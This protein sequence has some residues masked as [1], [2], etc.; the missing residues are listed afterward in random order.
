MKI[1]VIGKGGREHALVWKLAAS[2]RVSAVYCAPG[3]AGTAAEGNNVDISPTDFPRLVKFAKEE[4]IDLTVVGPEGPL[5]LGIVDTFT[6]EGLRIFGPTKA[7]A[8]LEGSKVFSK[9]LMRGAGVPTADFHVFR[10]ADSARLFVTDREDT[11]VV[12][13][14]DGLAADKGVIVCGSRDEAL[15]AIL[16]PRECPSCKSPP[17]RPEGE[18]DFYCVN[19]ECPAQQAERIRHFVSRGAM[20]IETMGPVLIEQLIADDRPVASFPLIE[21][22]LD[23]GSP[24]DYDRAQEIA[25]N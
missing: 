14:A 9:E 23:I 22:W 17:V 18:V 12:V 20:D 1:L 7:A 15:E 5:V 16:S 21:Q 25:R 6:A 3:N 24:A 10:D 2:P 11:P 19:P 8:E 13:K 4:Q